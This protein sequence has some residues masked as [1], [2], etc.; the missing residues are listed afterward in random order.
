MKGET[1]MRAKYWVVWSKSL[2]QWQVKKTGNEVALRNFN[3]KQDA[4]KHGVQIA[5][6]NKPSQLF[7]KKKD[8]EIEDE[9]TYEGDPFP[10][11][12]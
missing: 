10:P 8:G 1:Q 12:G 7:I 5:K 4:I 11:K 3:I 6:A 9:R 2:E